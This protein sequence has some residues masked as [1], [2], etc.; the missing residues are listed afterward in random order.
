MS[1][2]TQFIDP[3]FI[4]GRP[5]YTNQPQCISNSNREFSFKIDT[6]TM[7]EGMK[8]TCLVISMTLIFSESLHCKSGLD[9]ECVRGLPLWRRSSSD[10]NDE[11]FKGY[12]KG[13]AEMMINEVMSGINLLP[14]HL[15][16]V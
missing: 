3:A 9:L 11:L 16:L 10:V 12:R 2:E 4:Y 7:Q 14:Q 5:I 13:N 8:F 1:G 6:V 15:S